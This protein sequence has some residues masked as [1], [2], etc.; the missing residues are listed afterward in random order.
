MILITGGKGQ[1]GCCFQDLAQQIRG[2]KFEFVDVQE[3]DITDKKA[4]EKFFRNRSEIKWCINLAAFTAVDK[5]ETETVLA[6]K[7][8]V[9]GP[10]NLASACRKNGARLIHLSTDYVYHNRQNTPFREGDPESPKGFYAKSKLLGDRAALAANSTT[11]IFRTSWVYSQH[12][13]NF[14]KTMLRLGSERPELRVVFDQIGSP[15][16]APD[17]VAAILQIIQKMEAGEVSEADFRGVFHFSNEGVC[18][19]FDFATAIFEIEKM[20]CRV[21]P[22]RSAEFPTPAARPPFSVMDKAKIKSLFGLEIPH[23]HSS[24]LRCLEILNASKTT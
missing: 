9:D 2:P 4:V 15:T 8:N 3:L 23:W 24:L 11:M 18:S 13:Q 7:I 1:V 16:F 20:P 12:G 22:I 10:R 14:V 5:A 17:I 21:L 6:R 19:W